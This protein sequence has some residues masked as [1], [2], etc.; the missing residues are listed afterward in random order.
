MEAAGVVTAVGPGVTTCK[1]GDI[2]AYAGYPVS[3]YAEEQILPADRAVPVPPSIDP[4]VAA[5][6]LFKGLT[7]ELLVRR[8]FKVTEDFLLDR[9]PWMPINT[10]II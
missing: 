9:N 1:V 2:V 6:V 10:S 4:I 3:A 5:S 8:C 7:A